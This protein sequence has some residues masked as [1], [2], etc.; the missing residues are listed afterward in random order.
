[1]E[2]YCTAIFVNIVIRV[3]LLFKYSQ[4]TIQ[5]TQSTTGILKEIQGEGQREAHNGRCK[6]GKKTDLIFPATISMVGIDSEGVWLSHSFH[7]AYIRLAH[8]GG[9]TL[10]HAILSAFYAE[11]LSALIAALKF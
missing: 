10:I 1:M 9:T 3:T 8:T 7:V 2:S 4:E 5:A 6:L 11:M